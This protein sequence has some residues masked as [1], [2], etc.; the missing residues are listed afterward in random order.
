MKKL[1]EIWRIFLWQDR[2][3][4]C[5]AREAVTVASYSGRVRLM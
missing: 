1:T 5:P 2:N 3:E 4:V